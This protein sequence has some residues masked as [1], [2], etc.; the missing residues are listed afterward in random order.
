MSHKPD[1][2]TCEEL[3]EGKTEERCKECHKEL[4]IPI[5][6]KENIPVFQIWTR[7][8]DQLIMGSGGPVSLNLVA[9]YPVLDMFKIEE[10]ER[11]RC[12]DLLLLL[13][14][15]VRWPLF[16]EAKKEQEEKGKNG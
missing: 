1:C 5:L 7:I 10:D 8:K 2:E 11:T 12:L 6:L 3:Y 15:K 4:K 16:L 9:I 13:Y 14:Y